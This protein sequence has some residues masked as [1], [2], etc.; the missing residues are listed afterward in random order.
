MTKRKKRKPKQ[1]V[2]LN[3]GCAYHPMEGYTNVDQR[4]LPGVDVVTNLEKEWPWEDNSIDLIRAY[5]LIE[6]LTDSS[7]TMDE[8][9]RVLKVGGVFEVLVPSTAGHGAFQDPSHVSFWNENK[10]LYWSVY[11]DTSNKLVSHDWRKLYSPKAAFECKI[12]VIPPGP[13]NENPGG[14]YGGIVYVAARLT[15]RE[16]PGDCFIADEHS[17][18][19]TR[20]DIGASSP[21]PDKREISV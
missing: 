1:L 7:H 5:D 21:E 14:H 3:L 11:R 17:G 9:W 8:A 19:A 20:S 15:K 4:D 2:A 16:D 10:F 13:P 18:T 12:A 6:H